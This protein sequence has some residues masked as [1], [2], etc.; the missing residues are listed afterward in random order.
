VPSKEYSDER[1]AMLAKTSRLRELRL[2]KEEEERVAA[3]LIVAPP[4]APKKRRVAKKK[5]APAT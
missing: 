4:G 3:S 5:P 1:K 2:A